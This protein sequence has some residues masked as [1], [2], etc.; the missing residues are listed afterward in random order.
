MARTLSQ[1]GLNVDI[2]TLVRNIVKN[3][4]VGEHL[5]ED[6]VIETL[7]YTFSVRDMGNYSQELKTLLYNGLVD[8]YVLKSLEKEGLCLTYYS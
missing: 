7:G 6:R 3:D 5:Q 1:T 4:I 2:V 8:S